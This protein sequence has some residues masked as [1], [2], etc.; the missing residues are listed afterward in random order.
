MV[1][2]H[3][4]SRALSAEAALLLAQGPRRRGWRLGAPAP[5]RVVFGWSPLCGDDGMQKLSARGVSLAHVAYFCHCSCDVAA[6][7]CSTWLQLGAEVQSFHCNE[8]AQHLYAVLGGGLTSSPTRRGAF[9]LSSF[10][11]T[12]R[13]GLGRRSPRQ[14]ICN[15]TCMWTSSTLWQT[16]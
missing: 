14:W 2:Q 3:F 12:S 6:L 4:L 1:D 10:T 15:S 13:S 5:P 16:G 8:L 11:P 9:R 7:S